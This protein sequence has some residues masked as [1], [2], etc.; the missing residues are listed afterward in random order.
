MQQTIQTIEV[1]RY[2]FREGTR[3]YIEGTYNE[4]ELITRKICS[5]N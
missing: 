3:T 4:A 5:Q 2:K 1:P